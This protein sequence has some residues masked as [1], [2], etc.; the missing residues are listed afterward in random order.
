ML[1]YSGNWVKCARCGVQDHV[2]TRV[3]HKQSG[4]K[5]CAD[6][7]KCDRY[8]WELG[9]LAP[10]PELLVELQL[11][12]HHP[13]PATVKSQRRRAKAKLQLK[14]TSFPQKKARA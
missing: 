8:R 11:E 2:R 7:G 14:L 12:P 3:K 6:V 1:E 9:R 10:S 4:L 13:S 5:V